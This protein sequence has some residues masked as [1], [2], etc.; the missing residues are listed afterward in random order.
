[1]S[2]TSGSCSE[3]IC[4]ASHFVCFAGLVFVAWFFAPALGAGVPDSGAAPETRVG[5]LCFLS[6]D[7]IARRV[8]RRVVSGLGAIL[9]VFK[10][11]YE[12]SVDSNEFLGEAAVCGG[13]SGNCGPVGGGCSGKVGDGVH[14]VLLD[15]LV[16]YCLLIHC[17]VG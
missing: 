15:V 14:G 16:V 8:A 11:S 17:T 2:V 10:C 5:S 4:R 9:V 1:M 6:V 12:L 7:A 13:E 3:K